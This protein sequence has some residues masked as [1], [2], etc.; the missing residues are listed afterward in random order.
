MAALVAA[1]IASA[2]PALAQDGPTVT[3]LTASFLPG[4]YT[5]LSVHP[6]DSQRVAIGTADGHVQ[7]SEDG[8][9]TSKSS[10]VL[11]RRQIDPIVI[12]GGARVALSMRTGELDPVQARHRQRLGSIG[13]GEPRSILLFLR[14][15]GDGLKAAR[16]AIWMAVPDL[17]AEIG[18]IAWPGGTGP[19]LVASPV[20]I[21][22]SNRHRGGWL[23]T[24][25]GP[26][27]LPRDGDLFG[28]SVGID[29]TNWRHMLAATD[30]GVKVSDT[31]GNNW[32]PHP[33]KE[34]ED[35]WIQR[36][37]WD[38]ENPLLVFL[39]AA[40]TIYLS[41]NGGQSFEP[42]FASDGEIRDVALSPDAAVVATSKGVQVATADGIVPLLADKDV[43]GAIPW[44]DGQVLAITSEELYQVAPDGRFRVILR[45]IPT[46]P[47]IRLSGNE[48]GGWLLS[49]HTILRIGDPIP[50]GSS[51]RA[52]PPRMVLSF[53]EIET[54]ILEN[55]GLGGPIE[56]RLHPRWY[57]KLIPRVTASARG[58]IHYSD[59][60][61]RDEIVLPGR[62][63][64]TA[65]TARDQQHWEVSAMWDLKEFLLGD[66][67]VT[68]PN[69]ILESQIRDKR[70]AVLD[71]ART[72]YRECAA[73]VHDLRRPPA[74]PE[75]ELLW[76]LRVD[77]LASYLEWMSGQKV[78]ERT[79]VEDLNVE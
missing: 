22:V 14:L 39:V 17:I 47:Y 79:P 8:G 48:R 52:P 73:L 76:R 28:L 45:T 33:Q 5:S 37:V 46:D 61:R 20:G 40:D 19:M 27:V 12:R 16:W 2:S 4:P 38:P 78:V 71:Q 57:A 36:I 7:W 6:G 74:D 64:Q 18:E 72:H 32:R 50:R 42:S 51:F 69:M 44:R 55:T 75:Q 62:I 63:W 15:L 43:L 29:P 67:N 54:A 58:T 10:Q 53:S 3:N 21:L 24:L 11:V 66:D 23:R 26:N 60:E 77:E 59:S 30:R 34:L 9:L 31:G 56:T 68:N 35:A 13:R 49:Q 1:V 25:G 65:G 70:Q 41:Q